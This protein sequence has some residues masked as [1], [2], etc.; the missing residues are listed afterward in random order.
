MKKVL[1]LMVLVFG[2][3]VV[4]CGKDKKEDTN[5]AVVE[6][7]SKDLSPDEFIK[8]LYSNEKYFKKVDTIECFYPKYKELVF[9]TFEKSKVQK[10]YSL[11]F[12]YETDEELRELKDY[13]ENFN[14]TS[15]IMKVFST[16]ETPTSKR[17]SFGIEYPNK[18]K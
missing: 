4:G 13:V 18:N 17:I 12:V 11:S 8:E 9:E 2:L 10:S 3:L 15:K 14:K 7:I 1:L 16:I 5:T 6:N